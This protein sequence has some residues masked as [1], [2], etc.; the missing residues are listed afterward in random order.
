MNGEDAER[1]LTGDHRGSW[2][3]SFSES[4]LRKLRKR[5]NSKRTARRQ[6]ERLRASGIPIL[7]GDPGKDGSS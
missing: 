2:I 7:L 6:G 5:E 1:V 4:D 3:G